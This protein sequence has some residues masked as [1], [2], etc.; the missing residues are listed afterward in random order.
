MGELSRFQSEVWS[1]FAVA[2]AFTGLRMYARLR[3]VGWR[4]LQADDY[5]ACAAL[6]G[7][8]NWE[9][10]MTGNWIKADTQLS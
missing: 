10:S 2:V 1:L 3:S 4:N 6:V 7:P 8:Y 9:N 5:L